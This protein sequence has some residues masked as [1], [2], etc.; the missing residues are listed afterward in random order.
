MNTKSRG[1]IA[2]TAAALLLGSTGSAFAAKTTNGG[3]G[4]IAPKGKKTALVP[5]PQCFNDGF[6]NYDM[7]V[8]WDGT[9]LQMAA[10]VFLSH[11]CAPGTEMLGA[12]PP[13]VRS[14]TMPTTCPNGNLTPPRL[15]NFL[16]SSAVP[17]DLWICADI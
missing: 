5:V 17:A 12:A 10:Q 15:T 16:G 9:D 14:V 2:L 13:I 3:N 1:V 8:Q 6:A 7:S 4:N 11:D